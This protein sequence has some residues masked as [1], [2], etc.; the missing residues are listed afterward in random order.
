MEEML[1]IPVGATIPRAGAVLEA[2]GVPAGKEP[3]QATRRLLEDACDRYGALARPAGVVMDIPQSAFLAILDEHG[4]CR[5]EAPVR[6][7]SR[8]ADDLAL[9]AV[10]L[11]EEV[12]R[13]ISAKFR[14]GDYALGAM[15]DAVASE[16]TELAAQAVEER[17]LRHLRDT[18]RFP[19]RNGIL[20]F[21]PGFCGWEISSQQRLFPALRPERI[22]IRLNERSLMS[23]IKSISGVII[24]GPKEIFAFD[25]DFSFCRDCA[26]HVCRERIT[27]V[28]EE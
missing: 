15:L 8:R 24:S 12:C 4:A 14:D 21:S 9:Y 22:G 23:P 18:G 13:E 2:Q 25:D 26:T 1:D 3:G 17:Y 19:E 6:P 7:I 27:N 16:A 20:R 28:L 10:T 5:E 11:G